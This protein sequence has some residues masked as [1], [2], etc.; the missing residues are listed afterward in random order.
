VTEE[1]VKETLET[2]L[3]RIKDYRSLYEK[4]EMA[5]RYQ[6]VQPIL[7]A[8]GWN[9]EDPNQVLPNLHTTE[10]FPDYLLIAN[11]AKVLTVE[12]K[13]L[14]VDVGQDEV[15]RQ[16]AKYCFADGIKY[17]LL[18][19]GITWVLFRAFQER[20]TMQERRIWKLDL[21]NDHISTCIRKLSMVSLH[22]VNEIETL[23]KKQEILDEIW[24]SIIEDPKDLILAFVPIFETAIKESYPE[25][26]F[27]QE[28][29]QDF[30][31]ER[32]RE[33]TTL[34]VEELNQ[35]EPYPS[36][37]TQPSTIRLSSDTY[38]EELNQREPY[39]LGPTQPRTMRLSSDTYVVRYSYEILLYTA[40]WLVRKGKLRKEDA[41]IPI[42]YRR[43]LV[44]I[45]PKH[46]YGHGFRAPKKLSNGLYIETHYST[47]QCINNARRLLERFGYS[48]DL[49]KL[50]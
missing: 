49:L 39:P 25:Y 15:I 26:M 34:L 4:N 10:G 24:R 30:T 44:H 7:K 20:T 35:P 45:Q 19:N 37:P 32:V 48:R 28:E 31:E 47:E 17:G 46:A 21:E 9:P 22:N 43:Y 13:K 27:A 38:V 5:V 36:W 8:L 29:V 23:Q 6:I 11:G 16:L 12:T 2:V 42:G 40:E 3:K 33:L 50:E 18:T 41:P 14:S 1:T